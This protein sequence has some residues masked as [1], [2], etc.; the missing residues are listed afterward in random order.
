MFT[1][2][3]GGHL[4]DPE[5]RGVTD[6]LLCGETV[7][8]IAPAIDPGGLPPPVDVRDLRGA[9]VVPGL[10]DGHIHLVG[11]GGAEGYESRLPEIWLSELA[12]RGITTVVGAP[13]L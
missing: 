7:A 9:R 2:L 3:R 6:V 10:V 13:G 5:D 11:G 4:F 12:L 1:L 8:A